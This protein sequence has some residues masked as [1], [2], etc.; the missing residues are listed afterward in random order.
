[1]KLKL[2][3]TEL[4]T[5]LTI[6]SIIL[7]L[8]ILE[9]DL[10]GNFA[11]VLLLLPFFFGFKIKTQLSSMEKLVLV[12]ILY[13]TVVTII[14]H[15]R[16]LNIVN[17]FNLLVE[18]AII[19]IAC[20]FI[21]GRV[22]QEKVL[23][24]LRNFGVFLGVF[25]I[26]ESFTGFPVLH[27]VLT[28]SNEVQTYGYGLGKYRI[29]LIFGRPI[30]CG[31]VLFFF[32]MILLFYPC[33]SKR[34]N[35]SCHVILLANILLNRSRSAWAAMIII[36][37][38]I[39]FKFR[40]RKFKKKHLYYVFGAVAA[41]LLLRI[42]G[43]DVIGS[44]FDAINNRLVGMFE[45]GTGQIV[46]IET[47][48]S[49]M[50]YWFLEGHIT[51]FIFGAGKNFSNAFMVAH[52]VIKGAWK[53]DGCVDNQYF[54]MILDSGIVG[55]SCYIL[56]IFFAIKRIIKCK[57]SDTLA[58]FSNITL[59]GMFVC[60][61]FYEGFNYPLIFWLTTYGMVLSDVSKKRISVTMEPV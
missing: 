31:T 55:L 14:N 39:F 59:I 20:H 22:Y 23:I 48:L 18:Y 38:I 36:A 34:I 11:V 1:M 49:C 2:K 16:V 41:I 15:N 3:S 24:A 12:Y 54:T 42:I 33:K 61:F 35:I 37:I 9:T 40:N 57:K 6:L 51:D 21:L 32:W 43:V 44:I 52:P 13:T 45:A 8:I 47:I 5:K 53:W 46:R 27:Y 50:R 25:G 29:N 7:Y 4:T 19:L 28:R 17:A 26:L 10:I 58:L 30:I 60:I 56:A